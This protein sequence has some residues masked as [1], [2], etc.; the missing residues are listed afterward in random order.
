MHEHIG[1][2]NNATNPSIV[3]AAPI[4]RPEPP[5]RDSDRAADCCACG[6]KGKLRRMISYK[7]PA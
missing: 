6:Q 2:R 4:Q 3:R 1:E 5:W 7:W